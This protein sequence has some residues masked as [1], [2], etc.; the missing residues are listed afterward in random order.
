MGFNKGEM[1]VTDEF[2]DSSSLS[3]WDEN[4]KTLQ[5][6]TVGTTGLSSSAVTSERRIMAAFEPGVSASQG[7]RTS[8]SDEELSLDEVEPEEK[9]G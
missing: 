2:H 5:D 7:E 6:S 1:A 4:K 3:T 8:V 9:L